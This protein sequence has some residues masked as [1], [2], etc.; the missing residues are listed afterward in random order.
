LLPLLPFSHHAL[1]L[2]FAH[3]VCCSHSYIIMGLYSLLCIWPL[4]RFRFYFLG[5]VLSVTYWLCTTNNLVFSM[6]L[7]GLVN[8]CLPITA[9]AVK[10]NFDLNHFY[11]SPTSGL[12]HCQRHPWTV[13]TTSLALHD[14]L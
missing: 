1:S 6:R 8:V 4:H 3:P 2:Y 12:V 11:R 13:L 10:G 9:K 14:K 5:R 7:W